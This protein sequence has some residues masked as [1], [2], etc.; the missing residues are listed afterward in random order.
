MK[1][2]S[3]YF[4]DEN[5]SLINVEGEFDKTYIIIYIPRGSNREKIGE[6]GL[7]HVCE[8]ILLKEIENAYLNCCD[9]KNFDY[10]GHTDYTNVVL[11]FSIGKRQY[12]DKIF[13][14]I[15]NVKQ[16]ITSRNINQIMV[17][18]SKREVITECKIKNYSNEQINT[19]LS[20]G[21]V[22][23]LPI[24]KAEDIYKISNCRIIDCLQYYFL[25]MRILV[26]TKD[27]IRKYGIGGLS[28]IEEVNSGRCKISGIYNKSGILKDR[29]D[30]YVKLHKNKCDESFIAEN[31]LE[32]ILIHRLSYNKKI[33]LLDL[34]RKKLHDKYYFFQLCLK[35]T[36]QLED[37][38]ILKKKVC[39][40][41]FELAKKDLYIAMKNI[42]S[43][44]CAYVISNLL[45]HFN[46]GD[47]ILLT[48][49]C[50][51]RLLLILEK[52]EFVQFEKYLFDIYS[53][54][55]FVIN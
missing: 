31:I 41:E 2:C 11:E 28:S 34:K 38:Y 17:D 39:L 4:R 6:R 40:N 29:T 3:E 33:E 51:D 54:N 25:Y 26:L 22:K 21:E 46:Y 55:I 15:D 20:Q 9:D 10:K 43:I 19:F 36:I 32:N 7:N 50:L 35:G 18:V 23:W 1:L 8:H 12:L 52:L 45:N 53:N 16:K 48:Y 30:V 14:A 37:L 47:S 13:Y 5:E 24:G 27:K 42:N 49:Q 44:N